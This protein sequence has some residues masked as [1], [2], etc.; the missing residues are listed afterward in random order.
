[1]K[2]SKLI[3]ENKEFKLPSLG[4]AFDALQPYIDSETMKEHFSKH[5][6]GYVNKLNDA[7]KGKKKVNGDILEVLKNIKSYDDKV[8]N[9]AG[10]VFNHEI[11]FK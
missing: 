7:L 1:M 5:F 9:N 11:Y 4:Y 2:L 3:L 6:K 8:R 10:G